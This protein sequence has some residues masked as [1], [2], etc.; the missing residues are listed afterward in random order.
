MI[1]PSELLTETGALTLGDAKWQEARRRALI[2]Q[3]LADAS[4]VSQRAAEEAARQLGLSA[5]TV[6]TLVR[7]WRLSGS[8][9][10][11][12]VSIK[13]SGGRGR[14]RLAPTIEAVIHDAIEQLYLTAQKPRLSKVLEAVRRRCRLEGLNVPSVNTIQARIRE[15]KPALVVTRRGP[16]GCASTDAGGR[17]HTAHDSAT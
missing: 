15:L 2:I 12:L 3:P 9:V 7:T 1:P 16:Q 4:I 10:P 17:R 5:R 13:P 8:S 11:A 14:T 6:Y